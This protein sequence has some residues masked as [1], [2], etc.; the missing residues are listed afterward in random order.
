MRGP[1]SPDKNVEAKRKTRFGRRGKRKPY[2]LIDKEGGQSG[3]TRKDKWLW[4]ERE[5]TAF[6]STK[7]TL[8]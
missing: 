6:I 3:S 7:K 4:E 5:E 1:N 2:F 8:A